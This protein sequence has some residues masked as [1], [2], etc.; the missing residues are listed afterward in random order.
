MFFMVIESEG[1]RDKV[2]FLYLKY[3]MLLYKVA[4]D[5]LH[6]INDSQDCVH[7]TFIRVIKNL[8]KIDMDEEKRTRNF[9]VV[10]CKRIALN[11]LKKP[12]MLS[13]DDELEIEDSRQFANP[14]KFYI[15]NE[16]ICEI[17]AAI[18]KLPNDHKTA[19]IMQQKYEFSRDEIAG[20]MG[21]SVNTVKKWLSK[22]RSGVRSSMERRV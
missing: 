3:R 5:V 7:E 14:E 16:T 22:A 11:K 2:E 20:L 13:Y 4:Y 15:S 18:D 8:H 6:E 10:I 21:V 1:D 17:S 12:D 19:L 9:L